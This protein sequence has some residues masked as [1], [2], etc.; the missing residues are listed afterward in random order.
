MCECNLTSYAIFYTV[1]GVTTF[2]QAC[3]CVEHHVE[4][5]RH[6]FERCSLQKCN[7]VP[8]E[9]R[10]ARGVRPYW[11][12]NTR[13]RRGTRALLEVCEALGEGDDVVNH[14]R[15]EVGH[16]WQGR[17]NAVLSGI[18][19]LLALLRFRGTS[20]MDGRERWAGGRERAISRRCVSTLAAV[21][22]HEDVS[23]HRLRE[24]ETKIHSDLNMVQ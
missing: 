18:F 5:D 13:R 15:G 10:P 9:Q 19:N 7:L 23:V 17:E 8:D 14:V 24:T 16:V 21:A 12:V 4:A 20:M 3:F 1:G 6:D 2:P 11:F 22:H